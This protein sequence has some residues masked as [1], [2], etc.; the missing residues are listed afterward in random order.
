MQ[1]SREVGGQLMWPTW[2]H[3]L[4]LHVIWGEQGL[5]GSSY[6]GITSQIRGLIALLSVFFKIL[7]VYL[8]EDWLPGLSLLLFCDLVLMSHL[9]T[10]KLNCCTESHLLFY[11]IH[12]LLTL[13]TSQIKQSNRSV[14]LWFCLFERALIR[15]VV[16]LV[17]V[18]CSLF[19]EGIH[20]LMGLHFT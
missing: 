18:V 11:F 17:A 4:H 1:I 20:A 13:L 14:L 7:T 15:L 10:M 19:S 2:E 3:K 12:L 9:W 8:E 6:A 16:H 5:S